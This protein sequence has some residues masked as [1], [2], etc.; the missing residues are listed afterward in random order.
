MSD[1]GAYRIGCDI[2]GTFTD[3]ILFDETSGAISVEK[4]L[5]TPGDPSTAVIDGTRALA[6]SHPGYQARAV[7]FVHATTLMVNAIVERK[8]ART[9]LLTTKG[10]RDVLELRRH[11]RISTYEMW[12]DPPEP[13]VPR[14]LRLEVTERTYS[15]G[16]ILAPVDPDEIR[17]LVDVL[18]AERVES[19]AIVFLHSYVNPENE[20]RVAGILAQTA[21][22]LS[23]TLSSQVLPEYLEYE[24]TS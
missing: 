10:F 12:N 3:F 13:L 22:K 6:R 1:T 15:D 21:P 19:V 17:R 8:G 18:R 9:A 23:V 5:T 20:R 7:D 14:Y 16:R 4:V 24:R 11:L 2:G